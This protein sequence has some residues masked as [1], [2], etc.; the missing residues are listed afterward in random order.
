M[1]GIGVNGIE[2]MKLN[3]NIQIDNSTAIRFVGYSSQ[4]GLMLVTFISGGTYT[5][6]N[7]TPT[8]VLTFVARAIEINSWGR[9]Y[10]EWSKGRKATLD[11]SYDAQVEKFFGELNPRDIER[12]DDEWNARREGML[13]KRERVLQRKTQQAIAAT[14]GQL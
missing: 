2:V 5:Y 3:L 4:L 7:V 13:S 11:R 6:D 10:H 12:F 1:N 14:V 8:D 9:S